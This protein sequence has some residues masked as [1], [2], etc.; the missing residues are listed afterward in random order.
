MSHTTEFLNRIAAELQEQD[1]AFTASP[2]YCIQEYVLVAGIDL[3]YALPSVGSTMTAARSQTK[4]RR[5]LLIATE[6]GTAR[7]RLAGRVWA[8][9]KPGAT[10]V[11]CT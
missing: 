7:S 2:I 6:I 9:K 5:E 1:N 8:T 11:G 3:D 10:P 4:K